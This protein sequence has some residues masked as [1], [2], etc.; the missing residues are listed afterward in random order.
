M[1][2]TDA[3]YLGRGGIGEVYKAWDPDLERPVALKYLLHDDEALVERFLQ[4]ARLQARV[5]HERVCKVYEAGRHDGRPFIAMQ[6]VDGATLEESAPALSLEDKVRVLQQVAEAVHAAHETGVIHRDLKPQNV[7]LEGRAGSFRAYVM[8]FGLAREHAAAG[9]TQ[10][11]L[12]LGT[13]GY[14]SPEQARGE[15]GL[16]RRTDVYALGGILYRLLAGR[17]PFEGTELEVAQQV[18]HSEPKPLRALE[19]SVPVDLETVA[20]RCLEPEPDRRY[21]TADAVAR[22]LARFLAGESVVARPRSRWRRLERRVRRDPRLAVAGAFVVALV[23]VA[24]GL[25]LAA[26]RQ[27][28]RQAAAAERFG[29]EAEGV[30]AI[31][32]EAHLLPLHDTGAERR[33]VEE[34]MRALENE[35]QR[36]GVVA[37][38]PGRH[39]LGRGY[40]ALGQY[41]PARRHLEAAW[42][43]GYQV[44]P[45]AYALGQCLAALYQRALEEVR[46]LP[47]ASA[48]EA[49]RHELEASLRDPAERYLRASRPSPGEPR[50]YIDGL[51][52]LQEKRYEDARRHAANAFAQAPWLY[53]A[54]VLEGD[55][56]LAQ[57][58]GHEERGRYE[59][60]LRELEQAGQG[61]QEAAQVARSDPQVYERDCY[62]TGLLA[63]V[64]LSRG[65]DITGVLENGIRACDTALAADGQYA[66]PHALL[67][68]LLW[69][70]GNVE[71]SRGGD[72]GPTYDRAIGQGQKA[73]ELDPASA[74][75]WRSLG[76]AFYCKGDYEA[77]AGRDPRPTLDEAAQGLRTALERGGR[78]PIILFNLGSAFITRSRYEQSRGLDARPTLEEAAQALEQSIETLPDYSMSRQ[79]LGTVYYTRAEI[80]AAVGRDPRPAMKRSIASYDAAIAVDAA[81]PV[82]HYNRAC[83][84]IA[85]AQYDTLR[86]QD[87]DTALAEA[88]ACA[89]RALAV[90][91]N[92]GGARA[93]F[94]DVQLVQ[95]WRALKQGADPRPA[96]AASVRA[97]RQSLDYER[98]YAYMYVAQAQAHEIA[99]EHALQQGLS[100]AAAVASGR[101]AIRGAHGV[102]PGAGRVTEARLLLQLARWSLGAGGGSP[103]HAFASA[104]PLL[105]AALEANPR[106]VEAWLTTAERHRWRAEAALRS[107]S[108]A[109][110]TAEIDAG[111]AALEKGLALNASH[112]RL[113]AVRG[114]LLDLKARTAGDDTTRAQALGAAQAAYA[115]ALELDPRLEYPYRP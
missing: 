26:R 62:R 48:R 39:A 8:D 85:I 96:V 113:H 74:F 70:R 17:P 69:R 103:E 27:A 56:H 105:T 46:G 61:Y 114:A 45:V 35:M 82:S 66:R 52:A 42:Q 44:A 57:A 14:M 49:R 115:K 87:P 47:T 92:M 65:Q 51:L 63:H 88:E 36:L 22:E 84:W 25:A 98:G 6:Y 109:N 37:L 83:A 28:E 86:G 2:Y 93:V 67:C 102:D 50:A 112:P 104:A 79:A 72:P 4:E 90:N 58:V 111:L 5:D 12:V 81:D 107:S 108:A 91:P 3:V 78:D 11:G 24:A 54:K 77:A 43:G 20:A 41:E 31:L 34:R 32:R 76:I 38:G 19:P 13:P 55:V 68:N 29:R 110:A 99:G 7:M 73:I 9:L 71:R 10:T 101:A 106:D 97:F 1:K 60:A 59:D 16:D 40:L 21:P 75:D 53:E 30:E 100:P 89:R 80:D 33:R 64:M 18:R 15:R 95:A 94:G 23:A